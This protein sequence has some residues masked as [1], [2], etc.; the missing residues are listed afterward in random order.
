MSPWQRFRPVPR[1]A[2]SR[3][4][5]PPTRRAAP[6]RTAALLATLP[7]LLLGAPSP[8]AAANPHPAADPPAAAKPA[9]RTVPTPSPTTSVVTVK[10]GGDRSSDQAV[11]ALA[12]TR[13]GLYTTAS[14]G[15]LVGE[16]VS[17]GD[18]DC[19]FVVP[20]TNT[21]GANAGR[22][23]WVRQIAAPGGWYENPQLRTGGSATTPYRFQTPAL[24]PD[25]TYSSTDNGVNGFM[26]SSGASNQSASG[27]TWQ[28]SRNNPALPDRCGLKVALVMDLSGSTQGSV[29]ALKSAANTFVDALQGTPSSMARFTFSSFSP[30]ERGGP[31]APQLASVSTT[32]DATA[33][34]NTYASWNEST[35]QGSTNWDRALYVPALAAEQYDLAVV[36]TDG[37][38]TRY[39]TESGPGGN[40]SLTRFRELENGIFSANALK[41]EGTRVLAVGV[42]AGVQGNASL[43]LA[44]LSGQTRYTGANIA[45][46]D[47]FQEQ[48]FAQ[49]GTALRSLALA[50]CTPSLSVVKQ[51][52]LPDGST[53]NAPEGWT[54]RATTTTPGA[55]AA[56]PRTTTGDGTGAVNFPLTYADGT[57]SAD[58]DVTED[59]QPGY[60]LVQQEGD[61]ASCYDKV[62]ERPV[63]VTNAPGGPGFRIPIARDSSL[64]C[65]IINQAPPERVP[66]TVEV[67]KEWSVAS[68][69][70]PPVLYSEGEQPSD[71]QAALRLGDP[72]GSG[73]SPWSWSMPRT[74]Y[75]QGQRVTIGEKVT[76]ADDID[77][78]LTGVDFDGTPLP[79]TNE[80][81]TSVTLAE[82]ANRHRITNRV[83]CDTTLTLAKD[84]VPPP[85]PSTGNWDLRAYEGDGDLPGPHGVS[86][87]ATATRVPVTPGARYQLAERLTSDDPALLAYKQVDDRTD[88]QSNPRSTGSM[89]CLATGKSGTPYLGF[90]DGINGGVNVS[91]G[92]HATCTATNEA[93]PLR[94][95]KQVEGGTAEPAD[96]DLTASP[97][98]GPEGLP[99]RTVT[100]DAGGTTVL[101]RPGTAYRLTETEGPAGYALSDLTCRVDG[102]SEDGDPDSFAVPSGQVGTCTYTNTYRPATL[103]LVKKVVNAHGGL[104]DPRDWLLSATGPTPGIGG[105]NGDPEI[106]GAEAAPGTYRLR[107]S[108]GPEHYRSS[109][110]DCRDGEGDEVPVRED[111]VRLARGADV[112]CVLTNHDLPP[113]PTPHPTPTPEPSSHTP[114][115][116]PH[117]RGSLSSTGNGVLWAA[118]AGTVA[119]LLGTYAALR[120]RLRRRKG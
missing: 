10:T 4:T 12:G 49:V 106:T 66:A 89:N 35:A 16:C 86:G 76:F 15:A 9:P 87:S 59:Q 14:G 54:F 117:H 71:L 105:R 113:K 99:G 37:M 31:N 68:T 115:P 21:G 25:T 44:S 72:T 95:V 67:D 94:L 42:G 62:A 90:N 96:W 57:E 70:T 23:L 69:G 92:L 74:G 120:A 84:V 17:D 103:T 48:N 73:T 38:P 24:R 98:D 7:A 75:E 26:V 56:S 88:Y 114:A 97:V 58:F 33:F 29:R 83:T 2:P 47:Y 107:E 28:Q 65:T 27:G 119:L 20:G 81:T 61:N 5:T 13:L 111:S 91:L 8:Q 40:G 112:R 100:G 50:N 77:C 1:G 11:A 3:R 46:A 55:S 102:E 85:G 39:G 19:S 82:G 63:P 79:A 52:R 45:S 6:L 18:G 116:G 78:T 104:A 43:N 108:G 32:A 41:A 109:G 53:T 118:A 22:R 101:V 36:I 60:T 64:S 30:A 110:W 51:V 34:K 93:V 80:P